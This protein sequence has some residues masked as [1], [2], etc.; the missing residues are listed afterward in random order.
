M[1]GTEETAEAST[2]LEATG[3]KNE[4][5]AEV[6]VEEEEVLLKNLVILPPVTTE[7]SIATPIVV[8]PLRPDEPV[9]SIRAALAEL[10]QT[11][12]ITNYQLV[13]SDGQALDEYGDLSTLSDDS[14]IKMQLRPYQTVRE[15]VLR[16]QHLL[17]G[18]PPVVK[19]L[20]DTPEKDVAAPVSEPAAPEESNT[21]KNKKKENKTQTDSGETTPEIIMSSPINLQHF[22]DASTGEKLDE[23]LLQ[24]LANLDSTM[25]LS[26]VVTITFL[27]PP[28]PRRKL[29]ADLAY[30]RI[31]IAGKQDLYVTAIP[32]G[33]YINKSS[34]TSFDPAP[35]VDAPN[36]HAHSLLDCLLQ[37]S[38]DLSAMWTKALEA[39]QERVRLTAAD[40]PLQALHRAAIQKH[41]PRGLDAAL[42]K[43]SWLVPDVASEYWPSA[44][45][46]APIPLEQD[47]PTFGLDLTTGVQRDWNEELQSAREMP[48]GTIQERLE[49]AR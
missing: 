43:P 37:A 25:M 14:Q 11:A 6:E 47:Y 32:S 9:S 23:K 36:C 10:I 2:A 44:K 19:A 39:G 34:A 38:P 22:F 17:D 42:F 24:Q 41:A 27:A 26:R 35:I 7:G 1:A 29:F 8:P 46:H 33:F 4:E 30:L 5:E 45:E 49:R 28:T 15:H 18:N 13:S 48:I 31:Q 12:Q 40:S 16:L 21:K 3:K 20:V